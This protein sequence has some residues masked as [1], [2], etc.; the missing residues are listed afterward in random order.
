MLLIDGLTIAGML[1]AIAMVG[2][3]VAVCTTK[4][5]GF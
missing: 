1:V 4:G 3:I 2:V 5:C